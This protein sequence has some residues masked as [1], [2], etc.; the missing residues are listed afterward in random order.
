M[1]ALFAGSFDPIHV[2]HVDIIERASKLFKELHVLVA[3]SPEKTYLLTNQ[4]RLD[5]VTQS[6]SHLNNVKVFQSTGLVVDYAKKNQISCLI[7][8]LRIISDFEY[9]Q[10][11]D[12]HNHI[13]A[14]DIETICLMTRPSLRFVSS[15]GLKELLHHGQDVQNWF[16]PPVLTYLQT[17]KI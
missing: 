2:G 11:M 13:L 12:W 8:G 17:H 3:S 7:R 14:P 4:V 10:S 6:I 5:L 15:R 9:E 1:K 16:P